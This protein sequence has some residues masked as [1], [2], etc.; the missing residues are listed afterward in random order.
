MRVQE[1]HD[2]DHGV[3]ACARHF[4]F[5]TN[6]WY[7]A[8]Q[9]GQIT[10]RPRRRPAHEVFAVGSRTNRGDLKRRLLLLGLKNSRCA[11]CG[12][13]EWLGEPLAL[14]L[15][16]I[17]GDRFDNRVENLELLCPNCHSQTDTYSGRNGRPGRAGGLRAA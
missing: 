2:Q 14:E 16:H 10:P 12:I 1:F 7:Q 6:T 3:R 11:R 8:V 13:S 17:N 4:G 15:H 9:R 5:S